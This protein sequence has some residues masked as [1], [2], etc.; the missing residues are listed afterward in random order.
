MSVP[1]VVDSRRHS[2]PFP[3]LALAASI[4]P[5]IVRVVA[6]DRA[7]KVANLVTDAVRISTGTEDPELASQKL[8]VDPVV[9]ANLRIQLA[10]IALEGERLRYEEEKNQRQAELEELSKMVADTQNARSS[11]LG[12][13]RADS[14][15]AW[16]APVVSCI[17]TLGFFIT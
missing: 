7:G 13:V 12:L 17:V 15:I 6:G 1:N 14:P 4:L 2:M 8:R 10:Q 16:G 5:E 3:L 9:E 11:M